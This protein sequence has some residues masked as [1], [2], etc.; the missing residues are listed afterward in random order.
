MT[1]F[2]VIVVIIAIVAIGIARAVSQQGGKAVNARLRGYGVVVDG[3]QVKRGGT[4]L[5]PLAGSHAELTDGTSRHTL[6]RVVTVAGALTKKTKGHV[7]IVTGSGQLHQQK[8][9]GA[10]EVRRAQAWAARFNAL[11]GQATAAG[12][13]PAA[14]QF[15]S[16]YDSPEARKARFR[17]ERDAR[18][19]DG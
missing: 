14:P 2:I 12:P 7:T 11:A 5:G 8:I 3:D 15:G 9:T 6:T 17:Q 4:V 18:G 19:A 10:G 13:A 16:D 1:T